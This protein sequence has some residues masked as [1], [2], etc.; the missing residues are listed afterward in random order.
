MYNQSLCNAARFRRR[1]STLNLTSIYRFIIEHAVA[2]V[3]AVP[4]EDLRSRTRGFA[5]TAQARQVAMYLA[6]VVFRGEMTAVARACGRDRTT[7]KHACAVVEDL[8]DDPTFNR[9]ID[10]LEAIVCR[11]YA[12]SGAAVVR[13][14]PAYGSYRTEEAM[15][16]AAA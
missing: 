8:R 14:A 16:D 1:R 13:A 5:H 10:L 7:V 15:S 12:L 2:D 6:H 11:R 9:T 3:F 4:V